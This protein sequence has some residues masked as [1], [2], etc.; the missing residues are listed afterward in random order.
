MRILYLSA[1]LSLLLTG[2]IFGFFYAWVCSTMWGLDTAD[3][4][5]AIAAMQ[6]MNASVRNAIFAPSFF[7]TPVALTLTAILAFVANRRPAALV[8][9]LAALTY[10]FG[11]LVLTMAVNVPMN[12]ALATVIIPDT[13]AGAEPIWRSYSAKWQL[14]NQIRTACSGAALCLCG[15]GIALLGRDTGA[16]GDRP[17]GAPTP[18]RA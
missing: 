3:P 18:S 1:G 10:L 13:A 6:A 17:I 11:G 15:A 12:Q 7:G 16:A 2:A 4:R 9:A 8:F 14:W 5:T